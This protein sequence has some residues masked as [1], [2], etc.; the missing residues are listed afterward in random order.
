LKTLLLKAPENVKG[1]ALLKWLNNQEG[2]KKEELNFLKLDEYVK[3]NPKAGA[4]DMAKYSDDKKLEINTNVRVEYAKDK[5]YP[6]TFIEENSPEEGIKII[7][8]KNIP[9]ISKDEAYAYGNDEI[10]YDIFMYGENITQRTAGDF[11]RGRKP[12]NKAEAEIQLQGILKDEGILD[13]GNYNQIEYKQYIDRDLPGGKNYEEITFNLNENVVK[14]KIDFNKYS[15]SSFH[16]KS[17]QDETQFAHALIRDRKVRVGNSVEVKNSLHIDELQSDLH[18]LGY[19]IGYKNSIKNKIELEKIT[20]ETKE[21]NKNIDKLIEKTKKDVASFKK[22][23]PEILNDSQFYDFEN[24]IKKNIDEIEELPRVQSSEPTRNVAPL[25]KI[26]R[27][28]N[29]LSEAEY[30][31]FSNKVEKLKAEGKIKNNTTIEEFDKLLNITRNKDGLPIHYKYDV[32]EE[33]FD[34]SKKNN[35]LLERK[36]L[37]DRKV[38]DYPYKNNWHEPVLK[39]LLY[40][41]A[42]ENKDALSVSTSDVI[43]TRYSG[44]GP[45]YKKMLYDER[46]PSTMKKLA[47]KYGGIF[48]RKG[49]LEPSDINPRYDEY[50]EKRATGKPLSSTGINFL[51]AI[52][53][54]DMDANIIFITPEMREKILKEGVPGFAKGGLVEGKDDVPYTKENPADRVDPFTGQPYSAQMEELGLDVFQER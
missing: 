27:I 46:V 52:D 39:Q 36:K 47:N 16:F 32:P 41:A 33:Y 19:D 24:I 43:L 42:K 12:L 9:F 21:F 22:E 48:E 4:M 51:D 18:T 2:I 40:K 45:E 11:G 1:E 20:E 29:A 15:S 31:V 8:P 23:N 34:L 5:S 53:I 28:Y 44:E 7:R 35:R 38:P 6:V 30:N 49:M 26:E 54:G 17:K 50:L 10:G 37:I 13:T 3:E 14:D 25:T